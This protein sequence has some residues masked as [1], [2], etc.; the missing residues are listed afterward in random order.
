[1]ADMPLLTPGEVRRRLGL[2]T[3]ALRLYGEKGLI[4][5]QRRAGGWRTFGREDLARLYQIRVLRNFGF[6]LDQIAELLNARGRREGGFG[7][8]VRLQAEAMRQEQTR[9][10]T[11]LA[12]LQEAER[13][14]DAGRQLDTADLVQLGEAAAQ[15][16]E[17][18]ISARL[19]PYVT[20]YLD[21]RDLR[22]A[23]LA[24]GRNWQTLIDEAAALLADDPDPTSARARDLRA[25]WLALARVYSGGDAR[26]EAN[27]AR[28]FEAAM[29]HPDPATHPMPHAVWTFLKAIAQASA[30]G[31]K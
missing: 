17:H 22:A 5:P 30:A 8:I 24:G 13:R 1:M 21:E 7:A 27:S 12:L 20:Q 16:P 23:A 18:E 4:R 14:L 15:A 6:T 3:K 31:E 11:A 10:A 28:M 29:S 19:R 2:T 25:R 9:V 26:L